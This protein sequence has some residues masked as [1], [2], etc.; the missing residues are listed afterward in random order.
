MLLS[1]HLAL[2]GKFQWDMNSAPTCWVELTKKQS[3]EC[4]RRFPVAQKENTMDDLENRS[5]FECLHTQELVFRKSAILMEINTLGPILEEGIYELKLTD[6][7]GN[8]GNEVV[9]LV[10]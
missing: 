10:R 9:A 8:S 6:C 5:L 1:F 2:D 4:G 3:L 7:Y